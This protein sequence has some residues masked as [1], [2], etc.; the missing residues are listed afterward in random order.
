MNKAGGEA[1]VWRVNSCTVSPAKVATLSKFQ[2]STFF[3]RFLFLER[4]RRRQADNEKEAKGEN[5]Q[6]MERCRMTHGKQ[7]TW[8]INQQK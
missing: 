5:D 7:P 8:C 4:R 6:K 3:S 2:V 1:V